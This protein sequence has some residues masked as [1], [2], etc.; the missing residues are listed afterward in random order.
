M[1]DTVPSVG[2]GRNRP[3]SRSYA[4]RCG[5]V[6]VHADGRGSIMEVAGRGER[7]FSGPDASTRGSCRHGPSDRSRLPAGVGRPLREARAA[8]RRR[9]AT[10][11]SP[12]SSRRRSRS[13]SATRRSTISTWRGGGSARSSPGRITSRGSTRRSRRSTG[14]ARGRT[15]CSS[16]GPWAS[17]R[18]ATSTAG[19]DRRRRSC[20]EALGSGRLERVEPPSRAR[21]LPSDEL[22]ASL[23]QVAR[24][25][26][27]AWFAHREKYIG[28]YGPLPLLPPDCLNAVVLQ[29]TLGHAGGITFGLSAAAEHSVR[30]ASE[31]EEHARTVAELLGRR[32]LQS[33][34]VFLGGGDVLRRPAGGGGGVP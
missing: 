20:I 22:R 31:F 2:R 13:T 29:A 25:D 5:L 19:S 34:S 11:S 33:R 8:P 28:T 30:S 17:P 32:T 16:G 14:S 4:R 15:S 26:A 23:E 18:R 24:W 1:V 7:A 3:R 21:P 10:R 12:G 6:A 27:A 9:R